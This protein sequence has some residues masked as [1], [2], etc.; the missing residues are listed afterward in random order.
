MYYNRI[1]VRIT[2]SSSGESGVNWRWHH[3][4]CITW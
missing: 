2:V 1:T 3:S 4:L